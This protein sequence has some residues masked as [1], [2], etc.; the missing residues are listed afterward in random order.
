M[1][2][3]RIATYNIA[4]GLSCG[5]FQKKD[6]R[7]SADIIKGIDAD[8]IG[9]NE[10]G[11]PLPK[12]ITDHAEF[13]ANHCGYKHFIFG[14]ATLYGN[15]PYGNAIL[16]KFPIEKSDVYQIKERKQILPGIYEPRCII[17]SHILCGITIRIIC[18]HLGLFHD[19][20]K[21]GINQICDIAKQENIPT[22]FM[23]DLNTCCNERILKP[24]KELVKDV[25][26]IR[27]ADTKTF[28]SNNPRTRLDYIFV[29]DDIRVNNVYTVK[30]IGSDHLPLVTEIEI[31]CTHKRYNRHK[32]G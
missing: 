30:K 2:K 24:I 8:I 6:Y 21:R 3:L 9:L 14:Q 31:N 32:K 17:S 12:D 19:E 26:E 15:S 13:I 23:G 20:Q 18:T 27:N 11:K 7:I 5:Y 4:A 25:C 1:M 16:S 29:T 22:I 28:P 10:V